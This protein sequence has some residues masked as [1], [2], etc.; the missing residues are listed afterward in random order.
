MRFLG[1][2]LDVDKISADYVIGVLTLTISVPEA[3]TR[4]NIQV[5]A[6]MQ[7]AVTA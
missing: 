6:S 2:T 1:E 5:A 7:Q 3:V 4:R